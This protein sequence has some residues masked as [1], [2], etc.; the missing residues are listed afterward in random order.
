M[1]RMSCL[2]GVQQRVFEKSPNISCLIFPNQMMQTSIETVPQFGAPTAHGKKSYW[3]GRP[4]NTLPTSSALPKDTGH[5]HY[6]ATRK[7]SMAI[8]PG[9][10]GTRPSWEASDRWKILRTKSIYK[11]SIHSWSRM[12]HRAWAPTLVNNLKANINVTLLESFERA[13]MEMMTNLSP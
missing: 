9:S 11:V 5:N 1:L 10:F 2:E 12:Y 4:S 13:G 3:A 8:Q 7:I 6:C